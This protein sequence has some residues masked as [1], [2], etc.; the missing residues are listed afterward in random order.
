MEILSPELLV[1]ILTQMSECSS[2]NVPALIL[3]NQRWNTF[4]P[5][6][7]FSLQKYAEFAAEQDYISLICLYHS[8]KKTLDPNGLLFAASRGSNL[9][10]M[11]LT[12]TWGAIYF[13]EALIW[14]AY[15]GHFACIEKLKAWGATNFDQTLVKAEK[16][17]LICMKKWALSILINR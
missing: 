2:A 4:C 5:M 11:K 14:A 10:C 3:V 7:W 15:Y 17:G 16:G 13:N 8:W 12:K 1:E 6:P 9:D